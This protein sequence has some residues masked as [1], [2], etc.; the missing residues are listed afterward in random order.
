VGV[1][2]ETAEFRHDRVQGDF[3]R[4][5]E[6]RMT[7]VVRERDGLGEGCFGSERF[8]E[9][10]R[11]QRDFERVREARADMVAECGGEYLRL[12]FEPAERGAFDDAVSVERERGAQG[13]VRL[14]V[15]ASAVLVR[16]DGIRGE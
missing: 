5:T 12:V 8:S 6:R 14:G 7:Q 11:D 2:V 16:P 15:Q 13:V 4:V 1:V 3:T 9:G 10:S